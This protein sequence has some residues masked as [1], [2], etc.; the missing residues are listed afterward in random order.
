MITRVHG[1]IT[2]KEAQRRLRQIRGFEQM[3][4]KNGTRIL[5]FFLHISKAE[6]KTRLLARL[7]DPEKRWKFSRQDLRERGYWKAY[8]KSFE[9][10]LP[11]TSTEGAPWFIVPANHKWYRNL[12]VADLLVRALEDMDPRPPK[13]HGLDWKKLR[14]E[15]SRS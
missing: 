4:T 14:R 5:K 8:Q 10:A 3:L 13:I 6:Q 2:G 7:E 12:V 15:V 9:E 1:W 11:V